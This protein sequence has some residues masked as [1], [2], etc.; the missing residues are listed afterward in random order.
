[1]RADKMS[2]GISL[3]VAAARQAMFAIWRQC[4]EPGIRDPALHCNLFDT[5]VL[6]V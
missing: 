5:L 3:L 2:L 6:P 4:A 1:M